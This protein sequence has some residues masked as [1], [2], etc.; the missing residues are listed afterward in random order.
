MKHQ[1]PS[2]ERAFT[3]I[4]ILVAL[5]IFTLVVTALYAGWTTLIR[6][7]KTALEVAAQTQRQRV[8][9]RTIEEALHAARSFAADL[10]HYSFVAENGDRANLSFVARLPK[11]FP[12]SGRF[13]DL[14]VR[15][16]AF[17]IESGP[18]N[19]RVLTLRQTPILMDFD[20]DEQNH[21]IVLAKN[22][23]GM[24]LEFW[25]E[26]SADWLEEWTQTNALPR[27][28]RVTLRFAVVDSRNRTVTTAQEEEVTRVVAIPSITVPVQVQRPQPPRP[29]PAAGQPGQP[30][31]PGG[32]GGPGGPGR[33][34][35]DGRPGG[36]GQPRGFDQPRNP[37][38]APPANIRP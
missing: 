24:L 12:R 2:L 31:Q 7:S 16:V 3:L 22:V 25:D 1:R 32:P 29:Q 6:A 11:S 23:K 15:R 19:T 34:L 28:V 26:R 5:A 10:Q 35:D 33:R 27:M 4:E 13:G 8:A 30:G 18:D 36:R 9:I 17:S 38:L 37:R 21:P 14:D 20:V